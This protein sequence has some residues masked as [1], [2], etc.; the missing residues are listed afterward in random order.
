MGGLPIMIASIET[1]RFVN[2][3]AAPYGSSVRKIFATVGALLVVHYILLVPIAIF[4]VYI[5][6][7]SAIWTVDI[8]HNINFFS[9]TPLWIV[10]TLAKSVVT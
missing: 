6:F 5:K 4:V 1:I 9:I 7:R 8:L 3:V 2:I 10:L